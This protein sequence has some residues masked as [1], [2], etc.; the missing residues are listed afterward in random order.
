MAKPQSDRSQSHDESLKETFESIIIAFILAFVFRAYVVEAFVIPTGSMAPTLLG[1]HA[2]VTCEECGY[3]FKTDWPENRRDGSSDL[4]SMDYYAICAMC[5][6]PN[7]LPKAEGRVVRKD[8]REQLVVTSRGSIPRNGDR[9]LVHKYIYSISEPRR[10]DVVVFKNPRDPDENYI[11]RLVGLPN[12]QLL[13][14]DGNIYTRSVS[15]SEEAWHIQRKAD[16]PKVQLAVWQ[17]VYHSRYVPRDGGM[18]DGNRTLNF[19]H[20]GDSNTYPWRVPWIAENPSNWRIEGRRSYRH[21]MASQGTIRFD[22]DSTERGAMSSHRR[23]GRRNNGI[24]GY[25]YNQFRLSG[26]PDRPIEDVRIGARFQAEK[27]GLNVTISTTSRFDDPDVE[28]V[29][30]TLHASIKAD[31][32][33]VLE[34]VSTENE[35]R[36]VATGRTQPFEP[37]IAKSVELW[38]VDQQAILWADGEVICRWAFDL[39]VGTIVD[40]RSPTHRPKVS[41]SVAGSPVVMHDIELDRDIFYLSSTHERNKIGLGAIEKIRDERIGEPVYLEQDHFY[42]LGDNSPASH[43]S[44]FWDIRETDPWIMERMLKDSQQQNGVVPRE[45]MIGRAF[46]VYFPAPLAYAPN[47]FGF[48]LNFGELRFIH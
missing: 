3:T 33:A 47:R 41:I 39:P 12:E 40:R 28:A 34:V 32:T 21:D 37:G 19:G 36:V 10:W 16:R 42:C 11:K 20:D 48:V 26:V 23:N 38:Y 31:G 27:S 2:R 9:I 35:T 1:R 15:D 8:G 13:I 22:F 44:R 7:M 14:V 24:N 46:F 25:P 43:D 29:D 45:L 4:L 18:L 5:H 17:P 6:Y 30:Q